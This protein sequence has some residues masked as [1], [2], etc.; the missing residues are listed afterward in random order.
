MADTIEEFH[1]D[2]FNEVRAHADAAGRFLETAFLEQYGEWLMDAG[3]IATLDISQYATRTAAG[4]VRD[5]VD[6]YGGDP[7]DAEGVLSLVISD[8]NQDPA[9]APLSQRDV[10]SAFK[11]LEQFLTKA[12]EPGFREQLEESSPGYGLAE[13]ISARK[14]GINRVRL[15]L[16]SN[17]NLA[18]SFKGIEAS[19]TAG[20]PVT[21]NV[22]DIGRLHRL[23]SSGRGKEDIQIDFE[24]QF[25]ELLPCLPAHVGGDGY[26]AYLSVV[27]GQL[28]SRIYDQWGARLLEQNVRSFLQARGG[29]NKGIRNTILNDPSMFFAYNNGVTAT[30]EEVET[31]VENGTTYIRRLTNLQIVNGGQTTASIFSASKKDKADLSRI[32][33]QMKLSVVDPARATEVVPKIS[34]FANSQNRVNAADFFANHPFHIRMEEFSRRIWAPAADGSFRQTKWFYERARGSYADARAYLTVAQRKRFDEE[35]PKVQSFA[36]TDLAKFEMAWEECPFLVSKGA[37]HTFAEYARLMGKRWEKDSDSVNEFYF[38]SVVAKAIVFRG[39]ERNISEQQ[40]YKDEGGYRAQLVAY[41]IAKLDQLIKARECVL[42]FDAIW[43]AQAI[44]FELAR[45]MLDIAATIR[46]A[47]TQPG[48]TVANVTEWAKKQACWARVQDVAFALPE[49]IEGLLLDRHAK[50]AVA[51][52]AK[53]A[54][55]MDNGI[56][57]QARVLQLGPALWKSAALFAAKHKLLSLSDHSLLAVA[58]KPGSFPNEKQSLRLVAALGELEERGFQKEQAVS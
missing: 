4:A 1:E 40:W 47:V 27:P 48:S 9:I 50:R 46:S 45:T 56:E 39:L 33:V 51:K 15:F 23:V 31:V 34:E 37:Q 16:I 17:R 19:I 6:A 8:F 38:R 2:F 18:A 7:N 42:D 11:K 36:K 52:D 28:L 58:G 21:Y 43:K 20:I 10:A 41:T 5:R 35:F 12:L 53:K 25:G 55:K 54:Q 26:E 22:W 14:L 57:A 44:P 30:A 32:F 24:E 49:D 3:E 29:V 13:L